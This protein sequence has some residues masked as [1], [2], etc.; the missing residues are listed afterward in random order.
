MSL[1]S[2]RARCWVSALAAIILAAA[3]PAAVPP[4]AAAAVGSVAI[5]SLPEP[6]D[7]SIADATIDRFRHPGCLEAEGTP[8]PQG[9]LCDR[10]VITVTN[11]SDTTVQPPIVIS[12]TLPSSELAVANVEA[13]KLDSQH[14]EV[15]EGEGFKCTP[16]PAACT[17]EEPL[18]PGD[19]IQVTVRV[20]VTQGPTPQ[21]VLNHASVEAEGGVLASTSEPTTMPNTIEAT[22]P[23][24]GIQDF[25]LQAFAPEGSLDTLA[26]DR[27]YGVS[28]SFDL[29][30]VF[31]AQRPEDPEAFEPVQEPKDLIV[32]LPVGVA[33]NPLAAARCPESGVQEVRFVPDACPPGSVIG[34]VAVNFAGL[35]TST[36]EH[37]FDSALYNVTPDGGYPAQFGAVF[38]HA[39]VFLYGKVLPSP[40]GYRLRVM[41]PGI[42]RQGAAGIP[43][44]GASFS[45]FGNPG[46]HDGGSSAAMFSNPTACTGGPLTATVYADSWTHPGEWIEHGK[47]L[48]GPNGPDSEPLLSSPGWVS[49]QS[50]SYPDLSGCDALQFDPTATVTPTTTRADEPSGYALDVRVPQG[51][52]VWPARATPDLRDVTV[53]FPPG[54]SIDPSAADG[55]AGCSE[56]QLDPS[57][58]DPASCPAASQIGTATISTPVLGSPLTGQVFLRAPE[59][60]GAACQQAAEE[61]RMLGLFIQAQGSGVNIKLKGDVEVGTGSARSLASGL[62]PGQ[63][64]ARFAD[65]P[66]LPVSDLQIRLAGGPY[67]ALANP[68]T[69]GQATTSFA[70][71]PWSSETPQE[72]SS[73][74]T[75]DADGQGGSCPAVQPFA[76]GFATGLSFTNAAGFSPLTLAFSRGDGEQSLSSMSVRLPDGVGAML[77]GVPLCGEPQAASGA[78][79]A[80]S[81]IGHADVAIGAGPSPY[82]LPGPGEPANPVF[83]TGPYG[84]DPFGLAIVVHANAG[85]FHLGDVVIRAGVGIDPR[86]A[87]LRIA[88]GA[89]PGLLDGIPLRI[90]SVNVSVDR[91]GFM[92]A[93]SD[94]SRTAVTGTVLSAQGASVPVSSPF[95]VG[96]CQNMPFRPS[97]SASTRGNG[98]FAG[99]GASL[100]IRILAP[101]QGPGRASPEANLRSVHVELP[102]LLP[103]RLTTL[104]GAC[105]AARFAA[106]PAGCPSSSIV[107]SATIHALTLPDPLRGPA[108]LVSH[109]GEAFPDLVLVTRA[110]GVRIE[111]VGRTEI[112]NHVTYTHFD[113]LPDSPISSF[114]LE[115]P[116]GPHS[117]LAAPRSLC[118]HTRLVSV[119]RRVTVRSHGATRHVVVKVRRRVPVALAMPTRLEAQNNAV[120]SRTTKV[121]I[122]GCGVTGRAGAL[123]AT[124]RRRSR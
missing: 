64:R 103:T 107:G 75:L 10:Y 80:P 13:R 74:F 87:A 112:R 14:A 73:T 18:P 26:G 83:L 49:A 57:S 50:V 31:K 4:S 40:D 23:G 77:A 111:L 27:P 35:H 56:A 89:L 84:G 58:N 59:C 6:S 38:A 97:F 60:E 88:T 102:R 98:S 62:Q 48:Q 104:Q 53:T 52:E 22:A 34:T 92:F 124:P 16:V 7:F 29:T 21:T 109:G 118:A 122:T 25:A 69:C 11:T 116:E 100:H 119:K 121:S 123:A 37:G 41:A 39:P 110:D 90:R 72:R 94:C 47:V 108:Y 19:A 36:L 70:I 68:P 79:P 1:G 43:L 54:V 95:D 106:G 32:D 85:P 45:F 30:S 2:S 120:V 81:V 63:L 42:L 46:E 8:K 66:Q 71:T 114:E 93:P 99:H 78:C 96:G 15:L 67:A 82:G 61:G 20:Y 12:D 28:A 55:L 9:G 115:L 105:P 86:S 17:Y 113:H 24:F 101:A 33:A 76:P 91:P 44:L 5:A 65:D 3:L 117:V 51:P